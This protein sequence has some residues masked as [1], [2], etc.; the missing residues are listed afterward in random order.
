M[1]Q[2]AGR[3]RVRPATVSQTNLK[4]TLTH[5]GDAKPDV[6]VPLRVAE[7]KLEFRGFVGVEVE[8]L[9]VVRLAAGFD[10]VELLAVVEH[11]QTPGSLVTLVEGDFYVDNVLRFFE[12]VRDAAPVVP[13]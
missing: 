12:V 3:R 2:G 11:V 13:V 10:C 4:I 9:E 6:F 1:H 5:L 8:R 7:A